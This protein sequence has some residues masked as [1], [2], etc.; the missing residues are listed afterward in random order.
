QG[1]LVVPA[2]APA[3]QGAFAA[4]RIDGSIGTG[5][6][7]YL[8]VFLSNAAGNKVDYYLDPR[9]SYRVTLGPDGTASAEAS[10]NLAN[11]AAAGQQ[12]SEVLGPY[13]STGLEPGDTQWWVET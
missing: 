11:G 6:G 8:G 13:G 10:V 3:V 4:A 2:A 9:L 12:P 5:G 7:D 1:H